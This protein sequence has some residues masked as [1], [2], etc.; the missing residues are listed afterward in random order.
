MPLEKVEMLDVFIVF[1]QEL[2]KAMADAES[3]GQVTKAEWLG[4]AQSV[5]AKLF[6]EVVD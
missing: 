5:G 1:A 6:Q 3:P 4:I 2:K